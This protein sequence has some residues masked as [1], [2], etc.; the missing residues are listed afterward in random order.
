LSVRSGGRPRD[1]GHARPYE[2]DERDWSADYDPL[3]PGHRRAPG[4]N[5]SGGG[6]GGIVKFLAFTLILAAVVLAVL[7]TV[8]RPLVRQAVV[9]WAWD[10]P[11]AMRI[12]FV[13]EMVT[14]D[15]GPLLTDPASADPTPVEFAV[16]VG[17]TPTLLAPRLLDAGVI[18][19]E[20]AF[21][22]RAIQAELATDLSAGRF[23]L[24]RDMTPDEVVVGLVQNR[25][26]IQTLDVTFREGLRIEQMTALLQTLETG[27]DPQAFYDLATRPPTA[28]LADHPWLP[29]TEGASLEGYLYPATYTLVTDSAGGLTPVTDAE[30]LVRMLLDQFIGV[31][32]QD[33]LAVAEERGLTFHEVLSL[34]S[35]VEREAVL[36]AERPRIAGVYQGRIEA[37]GDTRGLLQA[38]PTVFYAADTLKLR[39]LDFDAWQQYLFWAPPGGRLDAVSVPEELQ[40]YQTYQVRGLIPGPICSPRLASIEAALAP[41][42]ADG[43]LYFVAIP[44]GGGA[45]DFSKNFAEHQEKLRKYGYNAP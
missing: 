26:T 12:G 13:A 30:A 34:A 38:D 18:A 17:D 40:G 41:D 2:P 1:P 11:G 21:L 29:I 27:V 43:F 44:D 28:L 14:E 6:L 9:G 36:D 4:R 23:L 16:E 24:R 7:L 45:H 35:I 5:G 39:D 22:F 19:S 42:T 10:N 20:Q 25:I 3:P 33:R 32:G 37:L 31:V 8:M 15:L